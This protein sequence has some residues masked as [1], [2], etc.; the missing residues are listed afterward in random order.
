MTTRTRAPR[1][2]RLWTCDFIE[3]NLAAGSVGNGSQEASFQP[4]TTYRARTGLA[5]SFG[6]V[7]VGRVFMKGWWTQEAVATTP[8]W[9]SYTVGMGFFPSRLLDT[10]FP[11]LASHDGDYF[12]HD[13][14]ALLEAEATNDVLFPRVTAAGSGLDLDNRSM[15]KAGRQDDQLFVVAQKSVVTEQQ[16]SLRVAVTVLWILP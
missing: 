8:V 16:V 9:G 1:R 13:C 11:D 12:L 2:G 10:D 3:L 5:G 4:A 6:G 7:T 14:R 15:R